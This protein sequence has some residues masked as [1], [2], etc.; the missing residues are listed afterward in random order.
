MQKMQSGCAKVQVS[1]LG[2]CTLLVSQMTV[3]QTAAAIWKIENM[4][5]DGACVL[6][7]GVTQQCMRNQHGC[8]SRPEE[9]PRW[10]CMLEAYLQMP[11]SPSRA[12]PQSDKSLQPRWMLQSMHTAAQ[13]VSQSQ[14]PCCSHQWHL[15]WVQQGRPTTVQPMGLWTAWLPT[16]LPKEAMSAACNGDLGRVSHASCSTMGFF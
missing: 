14:A 5:N 9:R 8:T 13:H 3:V 2:C 15:C 7:A 11:P 16:G 10:F 4:H 1:S 6:S 12:C